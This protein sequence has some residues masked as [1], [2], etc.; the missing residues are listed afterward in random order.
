MPNVCWG[1]MYFH[2]SRKHL[3]FTSP[4][5]FSNQNL[6]ITNTYT[7]LGVLLDSHL[8]YREHTSKLTKKLHQKLYV[9]NKI[10]PY[11]SSTVSETYLHAIVFSTISYC[12]GV[13]IAKEVT[14]RFV[15]RFTCH[16]AILSR[17]IAIL[18]LLR[19]IAMHCEF[20]LNTVKK[21][22]SHYQWL[23]GC[24]WSG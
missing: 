23:T 2:S 17:C 18:E 1:C 9:Y 5:I 24:V 14:I 11:L 4:I 7:Y 15:S 20:S 6:V 8:T 19:C 21:K 10:R 22:L 16:D 12:I 3:S 13:G